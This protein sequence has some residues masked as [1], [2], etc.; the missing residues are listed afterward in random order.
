MSFPCQELAH[1]LKEGR[2]VRPSTSLSEVERVAAV[3]SGCDQAPHLRLIQSCG[4]IYQGQSSSLL[5]EDGWH[6]A[7]F[8]EFNT[9][10]IS[11]LQE[12]SSCL[13]LVFFFY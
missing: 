12:I 1:V 3:L 2:E 10:S 9:F 4:K 6:G 7:V 13:C 8:S 5:E 11:Y